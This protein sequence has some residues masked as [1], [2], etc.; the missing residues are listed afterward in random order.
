MKQILVGSVLLTALSCG[1]DRTSQNDVFID[2]SKEIRHFTMVF[3]SCSDQDRP[4]PL[5]G[6]ILELKPDIFVWGG[7][8]IYADTE[9]MAKMQADYEKVWANETYSKLAA[10]TPVVGAWD[11]HDY[12]MDDAGEE[13]VHKED[14]QRLFLDF[15]KVPENDVRRKREGTY[16]SEIIASEKG[17]IKMIVLDTRYFRSPLK[18]STDPSKR[19]DTWPEDHQGTILGDAQWQWLEKE[20]EDDS[21][22]FTLIV[23]SIQFLSYDHGWERWATFPSEVSKMR[24]LL[25][26]ARSK[27]ILFLSGDRHMA[28]ISVDSEAGLP[29]P[30][31]EFTA[32]GMTH[33]WIDGATEANKYRVSNVVKQLNFGVLFFDFEAKRIR[34]QIR[35][36]NGFLYEEFEQQY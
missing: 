12:G 14:A 34:F 9:D 21:A 16:Y 6:P 27:R 7:D 20:L 35:G 25:Q 22:D 18:K 2:E 31:I 28:E 30:L 24:A 33:T 11:D 8:N 26:N 32:S 15:L 29:Y 17:K 19:Y 36:V 4:Q 10:S 3:A 23:S 1:E 5:W 13:W